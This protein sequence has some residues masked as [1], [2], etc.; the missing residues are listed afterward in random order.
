MEPLWS[1]VVATSGNQWQIDWPPIPQKQA[2]SVAAGCHRLPE[3][4]HGKEGVDS[5]RG[6]LQ[7]PRKKGLS[8]SGRLAGSPTWGRYG[9]LYG[10]FRSPAAADVVTLTAGGNDLL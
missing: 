6:A 9:A 1:P 10:A 7:K 4:F 3:T 8:V 2:E 5:V